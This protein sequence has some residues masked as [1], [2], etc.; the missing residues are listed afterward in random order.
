MYFE[1]IIETT[2]LFWKLIQRTWLI[3]LVFILLHSYF[4][5]IFY[6]YRYVTFSPP[7]ALVTSSQLVIF[8]MLAYLLFGIWI[9]RIEKSSS[10]EELSNL[11]HNGFITLFMGKC[12]I[13]ISLLI[14][15]QLSVTGAYLF[16]FYGEPIVE[17]TYFK[18]VF[19][20]IGLFWSGS[21]FISY[22]IGML[23]ASLI[24]GKIIYPLSLLIYCLLIPIN[25][26]FLDALNRFFNVP[27]DKWFNLGEPNPHSAYHALY[28]FSLEPSHFLKKLL[29]ITVI[30]I[31]FMGFFAKRKIVSKNKKLILTTIVCFI[32]VISSIFGVMKE[33][34]LLVN[35]TIRLIDYYRNYDT[36]IPFEKQNIKLENVDILLEP[37][38]QLQLKVDIEVLNAGNKKLSELFFTLFHEFKVNHIE[39][40]GKDVEFLQ[41][42]DKIEIQLNNEL[43]IDQKVKLTFDY[44]GLQTDLYFGNRQS[45]YLPN[46]FP[47]IPSTNYAPSFDIVTKQ[48]GL[49]RISHK[50]MDETNYQLT[51]N[52]NKKIYT[53]LDKQEVNKWSGKSSSGITVISGMLNEKKYKEITMIYPLTWENSIHD[54]GKLEKF[55]NNIYDHINK[56]FTVLDKQKPKKI[57]FFPTTNISDSLVGES[58]FIDND[59][60]IIG[61]PTYLE[62]DRSY[63]NQFLDE[64]TYEIV[65]AITTKDLPYDKQQY[66]FNT[67]FNHVYAQLL[68][69]QMG[70]NDDSD[71]VNHFIEHNLT[72][73]KK[74]NSAIRELQTFLKSDKANNSL[75]P[76]YEEWYKLVR[77]GK[78]WDELNALLKKYNNM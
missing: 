47:W 75:H 12:L 48:N 73:N 31:I 36:D 66:E 76:F 69:K 74:V 25:Y 28:G 56:S 44:E 21:F 57:Y 15:G 27:L 71:Y 52:Y 9:I 17:Y 10:M 1:K 38:A 7:G 63:F 55:V 78:G 29:I 42:G 13:G 5:Y 23:L 70:L 61:T 16:F 6:L 77:E 24:R 39:I 60:I 37:E 26:V 22:L 72:T 30:F 8:G 34:Q 14:I 40:E 11:I 41:E 45:V 46:Y 64:L 35:D 33:K 62:V 2:L 59:A 67:M 19:I 50:Y 53:N 51:I 54:F 3:P 18:S 65:P 4:I 58:S 49:H 43:G 68:N 20:Y 32:I